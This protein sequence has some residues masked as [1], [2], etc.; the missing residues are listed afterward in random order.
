M[1]LKW[2]SC[3]NIVKFGCI[4]GPADIE[5]KI[6]AEFWMKYKIINMCVIQVA[7]HWSKGITGQDVLSFLASEDNGRLNSHTKTYVI[8]V[9]SAACSICASVFLVSPYSLCQH[10]TTEGPGWSEWRERERERQKG[11]QC[12]HPSHLHVSWL[13]RMCFALHYSN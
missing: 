2:C 6:W 8:N 3:R 7:V 4:P 12:R 13:W 5:T 1:S 11:R 10:S 9:C